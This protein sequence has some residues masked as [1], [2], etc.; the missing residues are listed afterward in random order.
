[1]IFKKNVP[2]PY[3]RISGSQVFINRLSLF[4]QL[5]TVWYQGDKW[6]FLCE[7]FSLVSFYAKFFLWESFHTVTCMSLH[8]WSRSDTKVRLAIRRRGGFPGNRYPSSKKWCQKFSI[9][10]FPFHGFS[11]VGRFFVSQ[12]FVSQKFHITTVSRNTPVH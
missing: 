5:D 4:S 9:Q 11:R 1:M 7:G 12:E 2:K 6:K 8:S 10:N 3:P